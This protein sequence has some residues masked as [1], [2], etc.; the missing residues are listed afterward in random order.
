MYVSRC[1]TMTG[2]AILQTK[3]VMERG[4]NCAHL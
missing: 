2:V 1:E 3:T 4:I